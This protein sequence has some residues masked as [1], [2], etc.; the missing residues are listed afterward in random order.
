VFTWSSQ[1]PAEP[2]DSWQ[3]FRDDTEEYRRTTERRL[4]IETSDQVCVEVRMTRGTDNS[5][6]ARQCVA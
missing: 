5:P 1:V 6:P 4:V 3:L 2:G